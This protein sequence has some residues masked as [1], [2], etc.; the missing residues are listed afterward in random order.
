[1][2]TRCGKHL[3]AAL[4]LG[5]LGLTAGLLAARAQGP[6]PRPTYPAP[7]PW[8]GSSLPNPSDIDPGI[9]VSRSAA[10]DPGII[11]ERNPGIDPRIFAPPPLGPSR[12]APSFAGPTGTPW[13]IVP[14]PPPPGFRPRPF[15]RF[16][17]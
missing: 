12:I 3:P 10:I 9:L 6:P 14:V 1:M 17:R 5:G 15:P 7:M 8:P 16:G 2:M 11:R 13:R 4:V